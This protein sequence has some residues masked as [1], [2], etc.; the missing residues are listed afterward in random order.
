MKKFEYIREVSSI[1]EE[2]LE[3]VGK[4]AL[5]FR[6][7]S[8]KSIL[9]PQAF[10][11][12]SKAFD[13]FLLENDLVDQIISHLSEVESDPKSLPR[14]SKFITKLIREADMPSGIEKELKIYY[15]KLSGLGNAPLRFVPS[16]SNQA[17]EDSVVVK[18]L[19]NIFA[20]GFEDFLQDIKDNWANLFSR[21]ALEYRESIKY[22]GVL[23]QALLVEKS[24]IAEVSVHVSTHNPLLAKNSIEINAVLGIVE[25]FLRGDLTGDRYVCSLEQ[26][27]ILEKVIVEQ[28]WMSAYKLNKKKYREEKL[29]ISNIWKSQ[30]KLSDNNIL[31]V[32]QI[33]KKIEDV[34]S[35]PFELTLQVELGKIL[36]V[37]I[38]KQQVVEAIIDPGS[39]LDNL[40]KKIEQDIED[41]IEEEIEEKKSKSSMKEYVEEVREMVDKSELNSQN[42]ID[43]KV[44]SS[45]ADGGIKVPLNQEIDTDSIGID[46]PIKTVIEVV[47]TDWNLPEYVKNQRNVDILANISGDRFAKLIGKTYKEIKDLENLDEHIS[48]YVSNVVVHSHVPVIYKFASDIY[49]EGAIKGAARIV[50]GNSIFDSEIQ[51]IRKL[52]NSTKYKNLWVAIP[53]LRDEKEFMEVKKLISL[54]KLRRSSTFKIFAV[55]DNASSAM[56]VGDIIE[57]SADGILY[58]VDSLIQNI[59]GL[60]VPG[61]TPVDGIFQILRNSLK[62]AS[63]F[64]VDSYVF[65]ES[66]DNDFDVKE[67]IKMGAT[68]IGTNLKNVRQTKS[69]V[70]KIELK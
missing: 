68:G 29:K 10:V 35:Y 41:D 28:S 58:D 12:S 43:K 39:N 53:Y 63:E 14:V 48:K 7:I 3:F 24:P 22:E 67:I 64:K 42:K 40:K 38:V 5:L 11:I 20:F 31:K 15:K 50:G 49:S 37:N 54:A 17:L 27:E 26:E 18:E 25:P 59:L 21:E 52:R 57:A 19:D 33:V 66:I 23:T 30:Q 9:I 4:Q 55:V 1:K 45:K 65:G 51:A 13:D 34:V 56:L 69:K 44:S 61:E 36:L 62:I 60:Y 2:E 16:F 32:V 46:K 47:G 8:N 6:D 70:K